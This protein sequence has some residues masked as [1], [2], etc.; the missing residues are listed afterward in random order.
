RFVKN[1]VFSKTRNINNQSSARRCLPFACCF[2][3]WQNPQ[4]ASDR[5]LHARQQSRVVIS[6][7]PQNTVVPRIVRH[8]FR[9]CRRE[10]HFPKL[11]A[12]S[13]ISFAHRHEQTASVRQPLWAPQ[14][15]V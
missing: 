9:L 12:L 2:S 14:F 1:L 3:I 8:P 6:A 13:Q 7:K 15:I 11:P 10:G 4:I 5:R